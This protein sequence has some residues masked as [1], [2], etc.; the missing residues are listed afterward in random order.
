MKKTYWMPNSW[1]KYIGLPVLLLWSLILSSQEY[2]YP[3]DRYSRTLLLQSDTQVYG[4]FQ[5][6]P[7]SWYEL[8][9]IQG[10]APKT[11]Y[12]WSS[13]KLFEE[14]F[15]EVREPGL[16]L[17]IDPILHFEVGN[18]FAND[19]DYQDTT[20]M[21]R[22]T[23]GF[24]VRGRIG[25]KVSFETSFREQQ[26][27][28]PFYLYNYTVD[29]QVM[30]GNG[31]IKDFNGVG[32]DHNIAT[33]YIAYAPHENV[34][35]RF[36]S[37]KNFIGN[38]YRS[39]L[40]SDHSYTYPQFGVSTR[41]LNG[42]IRYHAYHA[43]LQTLDRLPIGD[44]PESLF[45]RKAGSFKY[46]EFVPH[47]SLSIGLFE[48]VIW[49]RFEIDEGTADLN[50][51]MFS[52]IIGTGVLALGLDD[53]DE[54][55][56]MGLNLSWRPIPHILLY[57]QY[58]IDRDDRTGQQIGLELINPGIKGLSARI[59]YNQVDRNSYRYRRTN[60]NYGHFAEPLAH[61]IGAG[62]DEVH[63]SIM[64]FYKRWFID[65]RYTQ[66]N[67]LL[68]FTTEEEFCITG[69]DIFSF[70]ECAVEPEGDE[71]EAQLRQAD[72][73]LGYLFNT[74]NNFN[75][76]F[77]YLYRDRGGFGTEQE[78]SL[79]SFGIEMSLFNRYEDF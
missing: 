8:D 53:E 79:L 46:L 25:K 42:K 56:L 48:S 28:V 62:F 75:M 20:R 2:S 11:R 29:R 14:H 69:G 15:F 71:Y 16:E 13:E 40:L 76:Y 43:W 50:P 33:G 52:P 21:S 5:G 60:Q 6:L 35:I 47:K 41:F 36:G 68:D 7:W 55:A 24:N 77:G 19:N 26:S 18:E 54:N 1:T 78:Q 23:R 34:V 58:M 44:T 12:S 65:A 39:L 3:L 17:D 38:G 67:Q 70:S 74:K 66:S 73:R 10:Y 51:L 9:T 57:G 72:I 27:F 49:K 64:Y 63:A 61:P 59:E 32:R 45:K 37:K 22:N 31:R 30:P 4:G